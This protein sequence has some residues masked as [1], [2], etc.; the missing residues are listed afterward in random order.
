M[1]NWKKLHKGF[2]KE[3]YN[4]KTY[5]QIWQETGFTYQD[6]QEWIAA[7]FRPSE[8]HWVKQWKENNLIPWEVKSWID[9]GLTK[10]D[11]KFAT[12]LRNK[13]CQ[14]S[15]YLNIEQLRKEF[16]SWKEGE[17]LTQII[18]QQQSNN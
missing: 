11:Y 18:Y 10:S 4:G 15:L 7:G 6:A 9:S 1:I 3:W 16:E 14:P 17:K 8:Y 12:Y 5:Q 13:G 2:S